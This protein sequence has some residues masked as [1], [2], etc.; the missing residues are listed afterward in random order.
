MVPVSGG[1]GK[2]RATKATS[3]LTISPK[4]VCP[5]WVRS[6]PRHTS[7]VWQLV[8][9]SFPFLLQSRRPGLERSNL[10]FH[11]LGVQRSCGD[12]VD[13]MFPDSKG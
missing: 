3:R 11:F 2:D 4:H 13:Y 9:Q 12:R 1:K 10:H 6:V 5:A 7:E 8:L